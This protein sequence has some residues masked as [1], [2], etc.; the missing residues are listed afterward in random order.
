MMI[1]PW[2]TYTRDHQQWS[3][4][5]NTCLYIEQWSL[6]EWDAKP[7][8]PTWGGNQPIIRFQSPFAFLP[9]L[10]L[11]LQARF[12][13]TAIVLDAYKLWWVVYYLKFLWEEWWIRSAK[14]INDDLEERQPWLAGWSLNY[15]K[16]CHR[17]PCWEMGFAACC[18]VLAKA[19]RVYAVLFIVVLDMGS[20]LLWANM[21]GR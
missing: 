16:G 7:I 4:W 10:S 14:V 1:V 19:W 5:K 20:W 15:G 18:Y 12:A 9:F 6:F 21:D 2:S 17:N 11:F 13:H 3:M 8:V